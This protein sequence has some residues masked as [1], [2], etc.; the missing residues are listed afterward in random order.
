MTNTFYFFP[1]TNFLFLP[2]FRVQISPRAL[3]AYI[4]TAAKILQ[5][6]TTFNPEACHFSIF[7]FFYSSAISRTIATH[8]CII[9]YWIYLIY[10]MILISNIRFLGVKQ[11]CKQARVSVKSISF[12]KSYDFPIESKISEL[13]DYFLDTLLDLLD[14]FSLTCWIY[15]FLGRNPSKYTLQKKACA[16]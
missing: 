12:L 1:W 11:A 13:I 4:F 16:T 2:C 15:W 7:V 3:L 8:Y 6:N 5:L 10:W 9:I 14:F